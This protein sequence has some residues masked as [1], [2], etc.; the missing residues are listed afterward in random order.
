[1][2]GSR[3]SSFVTKDHARPEARLFNPVRHGPVP[4]CG[5]RIHSIGGGPMEES[6]PGRGARLQIQVL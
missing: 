5:G 1:M 6:G 4:R 2:A 3:N